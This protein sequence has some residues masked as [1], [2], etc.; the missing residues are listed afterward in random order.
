MKRAR[1][2]QCSADEYLRH[3]AQGR[4][5]HEYVAGQVYAMA[6]ASEAHNTIALNVAARLREH[7]R[8]GPCRV[9]ISD[10]KLRVEAADAFYYPDI[11][12]TCDPS[13]SGEYVKE[14]PCLI[15]EV[16]SPSTAM[17]DRREKLLAYRSLATLREYVLIDSTSRRVEVYRRDA[18][19]WAVEVPNESELLVLESVDYRLG[20]DAIYEDVTFPLVAR[21]EEAAF[22]A[23]P[24]ASR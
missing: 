7:L 22:G 2:P 1:L 8:S 21:E 4:M 12:V 19:G 20:L 16:T 15:V 23:I 6:G 9:F 5:R 17:T 24:S 14:R 18:Q 10:M 13:D 3:E 11:L